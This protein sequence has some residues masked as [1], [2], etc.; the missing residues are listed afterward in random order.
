MDITVIKTFLNIPNA[1]DDLV[2]SAIK[3]AESFLIRKK[4]FTESD[5]PER[6]QGDRFTAWKYLTVYFLLPHL[7]M[8][9]G[10]MG[11]T[12]QIGYGEQAQHLLSESDI[13]RKQKFYYNH[14]MSI[15]TDIQNSELP[16]GIDI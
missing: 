8:T 10:E 11:A 1:P 9:V 5:S 2:E 15:I 13:E 3:E 16:F 12:K 14:A 6:R 7:S 4:V